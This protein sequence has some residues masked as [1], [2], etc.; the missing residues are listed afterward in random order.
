MSKLDPYSAYIGPEQYAEFVATLEQKFGGI[1]IEVSHD[2]DSGVLTVTTPFADSPAFA[3][4]IRAGD[5]ILSIDGES[6]QGLEIND[7]VGRLRGSRGVVQLTVLHK[8]ETEPTDI[9]ISRGVVPVASVLGDTRDDKTHWD[10]FLPGQDRIGY[11]RVTNFGE[12]TVDE[13]KAALAWLA[14]RDARGLILDLRNNSGGVFEQAIATCDLFLKSGRIVSTRGRNG[15][16]IKS[17]DA[18][19][20]APYAHLPL[21]V[22]VNQRTASASE[23][24]AA[25]LQDQHRA[26]IVGQRSFGKGTV[27]NVIRLEGGRAY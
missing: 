7:V 26:I 21:V 19:G 14:A 11:V 10:Y 27:Q 24:V 9:A 4:G 2:P 23:I 12:N 8:G 18:S 13:I 5:V 22:L 16:E 15:D 20:K 17:W 3:A 25:A 6:T 1:G